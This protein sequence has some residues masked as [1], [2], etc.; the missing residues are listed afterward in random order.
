MQITTAVSAGVSSIASSVS[1]RAA[2]A[3]ETHGVNATRC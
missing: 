2:F 3:V 1:K